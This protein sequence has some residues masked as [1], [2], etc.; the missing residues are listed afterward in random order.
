MVDMMYKESSQFRRDGPVNMLQRNSRKAFNYN[1]MSKHLFTFI[2]TY[3]YS[4][5]EE[6][7]IR[8]FPKKGILINRKILTYD[9]NTEKIPHC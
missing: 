5:L 3:I 9:S 6:Q 8:N 4:S 1:C 2:P 7:I